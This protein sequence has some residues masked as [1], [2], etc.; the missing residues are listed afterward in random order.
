MKKLQEQL[1]NA[2]NASLRWH[3]ENDVRLALMEILKQFDELEKQEE[4]KPE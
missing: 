3:S 4:E 2:V 1:V